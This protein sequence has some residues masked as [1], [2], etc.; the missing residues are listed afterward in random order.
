MARAVGLTDSEANMTGHLMFDFE[1]KGSGG[2]Q[3]RQALA[4]LRA[5]LGDDSPLVA[6]VCRIG[7]TALSSYEAPAPRKFI[8]PVGTV[9]SL[10]DP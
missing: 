8:Y 7:Y 4:T 2:K 1:S 9:S 10:I 6:D 5:T 3:M